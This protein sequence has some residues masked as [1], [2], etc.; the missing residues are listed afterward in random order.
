M[1]IF[2]NYFYLI[3]KLVG[4][5]MLECNINSDNLI[6]DKE[7]IENK[8]VEINTFKSNIKAD[9]LISNEENIENTKEEKITEIQQKEKE[10]KVT[11]EI[12]FSKENSR[13]IQDK[14]PKKE[15]NKKNLEDSSI[16][17]YFVETKKLIKDYK[18][19]INEFD[20]GVIKPLMNKSYQLLQFEKML[21]EKQKQLEK[22]LKEEN[23]EIEKE[24]NL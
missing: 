4:Q 2:I 24:K 18:A 8:F 23:E 11:S 12:K 6:S 22:K 16:Q 14:E 1:P 13:N 7:N 19:A 21:D 15:T 9:N 20:G 10:S 5:N 17:K 3:G